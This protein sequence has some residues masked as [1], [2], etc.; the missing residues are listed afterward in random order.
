M[1]PQHERLVRNRIVGNRFHRLSLNRKRNGRLLFRSPRMGNPQTVADHR[2]FAI[3]E[4]I[5]TV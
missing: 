5:S 1:V 4:G 2:V 3:E